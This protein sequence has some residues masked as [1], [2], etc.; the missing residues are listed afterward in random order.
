[1]CVYTVHGG[2]TRFRAVGGERISG[3]IG[4]TATVIVPASTVWLICV[5]QRGSFNFCDSSN[6]R[7]PK[8]CKRRRLP[9]T[10][11]V[12]DDLPKHNQ[13]ANVLCCWN[14]KSEKMVSLGSR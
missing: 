4:R 5:I 14:A 1:M 8:E 3:W 13:Q 10:I 9:P 6:L 12:Q 11:V 7:K 2:D